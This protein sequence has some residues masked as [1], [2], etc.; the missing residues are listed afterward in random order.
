M[1]D[2]ARFIGTSLSASFTVGDLAASVRWY[3]EVIGFAV[4]R[5]HERE[6]KLIAVSLRAGDVRILLTQDNGERGTDRVKGAGFSLQITTA[7]SLDALAAAIKERGGVLESEP[8][9]TPWG[10][11]MFRLLDPDGFRFTISSETV[12]PRQSQH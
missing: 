12:S 10:V 3:S 11:R 6:G 7:Q 4:D 5:K 2:G 1:S 9:D 8:V